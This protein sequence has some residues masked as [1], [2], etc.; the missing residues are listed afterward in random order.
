MTVDRSFRDPRHTRLSAPALDASVARADGFQQRLELRT[1]V[2]GD[3]WL[4]CSD[5]LADPRGFLPWWAALARWLR[6][7][8]GAAP[9]RTVA[10]Y[11]MSWYLRIPAYVGALLFFHERRVPWLR[12]EELALRIAG[13]GRPH[14]VGIA[15]LGKRFHCLPLDPGSTGP[16]ATVAADERALAAVLR[17][18]FTGHAAEFVR[19][20]RRISPLGTRMLWAAATDAL[21]DSLWWAGRDA[22]DEG[23]GVADATLVLESAFPPLTSR[24]T[25]RLTEEADGGRTWT[26]RRESCCFTYLLPGRDEC[27]GCPRRCPKQG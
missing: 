14:P 25:L 1:E 4:R 24:S 5:L 18:R 19:G 17:A 26:R 12:P 6:K 27:A 23:G 9:D 13:E 2:S 16:E 8:Y 20:Y 3:G 21:D 22:G 10:A 11:V 15:V 7:E